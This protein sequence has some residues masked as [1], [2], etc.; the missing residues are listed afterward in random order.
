MKTVIALSFTLLS[1]LTAHAAGEN[2]GRGGDNRSLATGSMWFMDANRAVTAC[3]EMSGSFGVSPKKVEED[4][5]YAYAAWKEY[6]LKKSKAVDLEGDFSDPID[7]PSFRLKILPK[8]NGREDLKLYLG[9]TDAKVT[10][11]SHEY[12]N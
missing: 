8:C 9:V 6:F 7:Q 10:L 5:K 1:T 11:A 2:G 4:L 3:Y 12:E